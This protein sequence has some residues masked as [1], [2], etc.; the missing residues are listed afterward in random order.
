MWLGMAQNFQLAVSSSDKHHNTP[1]A[2]PRSE[3]NEV[4]GEWDEVFAVGDIGRQ[5]GQV[6]Y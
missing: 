1:L 2:T 3:D 5:R 4:Q 6:C